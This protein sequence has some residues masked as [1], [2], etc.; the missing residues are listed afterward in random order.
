MDFWFGDIETIN[1]EILKPYRRQVRKRVKIGILDTGVDMNNKVLQKAEV[2]K[3]IK[4]TV[5]FCSPNGRGTGRDLCGHG[6][7]GVAL[8]N[9][10]A[11]EANIYVGRVA[12][13]FESGLDE[14]VIA[15]VNKK[16]DF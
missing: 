15:K 16:Q 6:T 13:D 7:Y 8:I 4:K 11:P 5:D 9:R 2:R 12:V 3:R 10:V 1:E 14:N